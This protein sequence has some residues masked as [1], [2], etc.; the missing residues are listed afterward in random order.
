MFTDAWLTCSQV[1]PEGH[2]GAPGSHS[3]RALGMLGFSVHAAPSATVAAAANPKSQDRPTR[4]D[5]RTSQNRKLRTPPA[6][7]GDNVG[8]I[9]TAAWSAAG[10]DPPNPPASRNVV[11]APARAATPSP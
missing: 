2:L 8:V 1:K 11:A 5:M 10:P 4:L 3:T 6:P 9:A 7:P